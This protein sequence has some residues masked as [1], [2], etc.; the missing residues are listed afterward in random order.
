MHKVA[1]ADTTIASLYSAFYDDVTN[2]I[3]CVLMTNN[4]AVYTIDIDTGI[5][6]HLVDLNPQSASLELTGSSFDQSTG[7]HY[8]LLLVAGIDQVLYSVNTRSPTAR[9]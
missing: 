9:T 7:I 3:K 1:L 5:A 2:T 8:Q 6:E 4:T